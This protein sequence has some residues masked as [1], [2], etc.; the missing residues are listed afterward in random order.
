MAFSSYLVSYKNVASAKLVMHGDYTTQENQ[1]I[2]SSESRSDIVELDSECE[3]VL[4]NILIYFIY[5]F[6]FTYV[7]A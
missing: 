6:L 7:K 4:K 2:T 5:F 1:N 3:G